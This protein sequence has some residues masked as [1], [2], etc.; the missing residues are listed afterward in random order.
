MADQKANFWTGAV[1]AVFASSLLVWVIPQY[2]GGGFSHGLP[3]QLVA[4]IG[5][6]I[7]LIFA[8]FLCIQSLV[9]IWR[10]K[11]KIASA[12]SL[13]ETWH[14]IWPFLYVLVFIFAATMLPL[15]WVGAFLIFGLL[16]ILNER[17]WLI[18]ITVSALPPLALYVLT[19]HL[20]KIGV[21]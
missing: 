13:K 18:L 15:T 16:W 10:Q 4:T 8:L 12:P 19:V 17:R 3:P 6:W 1:S 21:V 2:G 7:M 11:S 14:Q 9:T 20:M 5:A